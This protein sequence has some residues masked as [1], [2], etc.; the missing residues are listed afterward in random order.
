MSNWGL[1]YVDCIKGTVTSIGKNSSTTQRNHRASDLAPDSYGETNSEAVT[2]H[3][4]TSFENGMV[5]GSL[6]EVGF[7][8]CL[9]FL[10]L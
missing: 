8:L 6:V 10:Y 9:N 1:T 2:S 3:D 4:V 7:H 5:E